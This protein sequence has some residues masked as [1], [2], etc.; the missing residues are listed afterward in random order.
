MPV[1]MNLCTNAAQFLNDAIANLSDLPDPLPEDET[2][3]TT[4]VY[5]DP[6]QLSKQTII[7]LWCENNHELDD[8]QQYWFCTGMTILRF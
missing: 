1:E 3:R 7:D 6:A 2:D 8:E 4:D 5:F